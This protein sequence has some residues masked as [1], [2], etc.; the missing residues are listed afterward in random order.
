[1]TQMQH[2]FESETIFK[3]D[4]SFLLPGVLYTKQSSDAG[5]I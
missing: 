1:M 3:K 4:L 2:V 5:H